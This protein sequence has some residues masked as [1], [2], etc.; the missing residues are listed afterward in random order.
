[1]SI[2]PL[3][4]KDLIDYFFRV[5]D[6]NRS[7]S[8]LHHNLDAVLKEK[9]NMKELALVLYH[10]AI[11]AVN[12][13]YGDK[14]KAMRVIENHVQGWTDKV[15]RQS[16]GHTPYTLSHIVEAFGVL[17]LRP[18]ER[19]REFLEPRLIAAVPAMHERD[20]TSML[21]GLARLGMPLD[22][23]FY[24]AV[25]QRMPQIKHEFPAQGIYQIFHSLAILDAVGQ[26]HH[27]KKKLPLNDIFTPL[28]NDPQIRQKLAEREDDASRRMLL[29]SVYWFKGET[30][31]RY[32]PETGGKSFFETDV[33]AAL[34]H[35][36]AQMKD[37]KPHPVSRHRID[38]AG[39]FNKTSFVVECDGPD[40]FVRCTDNHTSMLDGNTLFQTALIARRDP[41]QKMLRLPYDVFY[42]NMDNTEMWEYL[43]LAV[44]EAK[45][46]SYIVGPA[47]DLLSLNE[48]FDPGLPYEDHVGH[49][50]LPPAVT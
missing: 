16:E 4:K 21:G 13:V 26:L 43:L 20:M 7:V 31:L 9:L 8:G 25:Q 37:T 49:Q 40:H 27:G 5:E 44:E 1:M 6:G 19:L 28:L 36:G 14:I 15:V 11:H 32:S 23:K 24:Q 22:K 18:P 17:R 12:G 34:Q 35:A 38:L 46:G 29:D 45:E 39:Q 3:R 41:G 2:T 33:A 50:I 10:S 48:G 30:P 42:A 47:G